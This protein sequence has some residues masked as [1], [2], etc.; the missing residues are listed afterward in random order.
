MSIKWTKE[1][2]LKHLERR[3]KYYYNN[4]DKVKQ[5]KERE[6]INRL[7]FREF[8]SKLSDLEKQQYFAE[9]YGKQKA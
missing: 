9:K 5:W 4:L 6:K 7:E 8:F 3:R 2:Y 1:K